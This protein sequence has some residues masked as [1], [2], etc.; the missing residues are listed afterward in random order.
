[1]NKLCRILTVFL[2]LAQIFI[3]Y[4]CSSQSESTDL[5]AG[6]YEGEN[7]D[8]VI[9]KYEDYYGVRMYLRGIVP[10]ETVII[11]GEGHIER[12]TLFFVATDTYGNSFK[13]NVEEYGSDYPVRVELYEKMTN[14]YIDEL[15]FERKK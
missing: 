14:E 9:Q 1:M 8:L 11:W 15:E 13:G 3:L 2:L 5:Y 6:M 10:D 12:G 7:G 4:G